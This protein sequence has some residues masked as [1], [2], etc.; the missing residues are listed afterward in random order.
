MSD[1]H[2]LKED[3]EKESKSQKPKVRKPG[4][5]KLITTLKEKDKLFEFNVP[6]QLLKLYDD[7]ALLA[8]L[9]T[10][11]SQK[12]FIIDDADNVKKYAR[13]GDFV[14][15]K[16]RWETT[17]VI[18]KT[19]ETGVVKNKDGKFYVQFKKSSYWIESDDKLINQKNLKVISEPKSL[20]RKQKYDSKPTLNT[21]E[22]IKKGMI[23]EYSGKPLEEDKKYVSNGARG[24]IVMIDKNL[25]DEKGNPIGEHDHQKRNPMFITWLAGEDCKLTTWQGYNSEKFSYYPDKL[26]YPKDVQLIKKNNIDYQALYKTHVIRE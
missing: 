11:Y 9:E 5:E 22:Q 21:F 13:A 12:E 17:K 6:S 19:C 23:V 4:L 16:E 8:H 18:V 14:L 2:L 7:K 1:P 26:F 25:S 24:V 10:V 15:K 20:G 3:R